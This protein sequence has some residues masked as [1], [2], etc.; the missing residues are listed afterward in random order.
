ML[1]AIFDD[2]LDVASN[3][4]ICAGTLAMFCLGQGLFWISVGSKQFENVIKDKVQIAKVFLEDESNSSLKVAFCSKLK[5]QVTS[6]TIENIKTTQ[7]ENIQMMKNRFWGFFSMAAL[8]FVIMLVIV[9]YLF[10]SRIRTAPDG[11]RLRAKRWGFFLA[12]F[13]VLFSFSTEIFIFKFI[14][15]PYIIIGDM[16]M[17]SEMI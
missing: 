16:E 10:N 1:S 5:S 12:L 7:E 2:R 15:E 4:C 6:K 17:L 13:L 9:L 8:V 11:T 14:I 3:L